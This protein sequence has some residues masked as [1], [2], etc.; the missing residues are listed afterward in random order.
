MADGSDTLERLRRLRG[1]S[2]GFTDYRGRTRPLSMEALRG[3]L[4]AFG[5]EVD[6]GSLQDEAEALEE[7][8]WT[9]VLP[10]VVV[11]R[12]DRQV[13]LT[14]L[15]PL[16]PSIHWRVELEDG[17]VVAG[18]FD[19]AGLPVL[20]ER[21]IGG[22]WYV[23]LGFELP[24]LPH[25]YHRLRLEKPDGL[26]LASTRLVVAPRACHQ[27]RSITEGA[28]IWGPAI[29]LYTLRSQRNWGIGDFTD[30]AGFVQA[31]ADL[32]ADVV[33]LNPLHAL[34][35]AEPAMSGPYSPSSRYFL[36][37]LYIDPEAIPEFAQTVEARRLVAASEFQARLAELR[38]APF[39]DYEG[40]AACKLETLRLIFAAFEAGARTDRVLE[41]ERFITK[42]SEHIVT[43]ALFHAL[44]DHFTAAGTLGGWPAWPAPYQDP[45]G[46][47]A[48]A[49]LDA[50]PGAV[51]FHCWLQWIAHAQLEGAEQQAREAGLRLGLYRDLAVGPNGGGA[52]TWAGRG[53]YADGAT[54]GAPP[55]PL[56]P[57][58]QDWGIPPYHPD[59]L[60]EQ[61]YEP[62][63]RLLRANMVEGGALRID[64]VMMLFRLWW[65]PRGSGSADGGYV[66]YRLE[67]LM[68]LVALE[69][70]RR[71][72][73]V[74]GEDLGT[75]PPEVREAM[76]AHGI[77]SYRVLFFERREDGSF[78]LPAE[79]PRES[80]VTVSTHDLPPLA[81][82]WAGSDIA[83]SE[84]LGI[85]PEPDQAEAERAARAD[86]RRALLE[87]LSATGLLPAGLTPHDP[88]LQATAKLALAVQ[89]YLASAPAAVLMLQP[90]DWL[91]MDTPVNVPG[92]HEVYPNW[93]RKLTAEWPEFMARDDVRT[94]AASV[95]DLRRGPV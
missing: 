29:Q 28:R 22:L 77:Y 54:V 76:R 61:G 86:T 14:V 95:T 46:P 94:L 10:P 71:R 40:V 57:H 63:I 87:A 25:G 68:A 36:N 51:R 83:L 48:Q 73:L 13:C 4:S 52:E 55:D 88:P 26:P 66:H 85:Y 12:N 58:G 38:A 31:A 30:L 79:Y 9:R 81:S 84:R 56:A 27:P 33:G 3:L 59:A 53:C 65:V 35:P 15:A 69:S 43:F 50:N 20:A 21:G 37:V 24:I 67:E 44:Q 17:E 1:I 80:L 6:G 49:F 7:R 2:P 91:G 72:C 47:A 42:H 82:F 60:R 62:F 5:H 19:P 8:G 78:R 75:V 11:L 90:E 39:V 93:G 32:G 89:R 70:E 92:T 34:F 74:I 16:L 23:R 18:E 45:A 41:F 64:H